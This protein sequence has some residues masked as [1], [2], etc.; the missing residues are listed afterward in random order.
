MQILVSSE[1][2]PNLKTGA[3]V[4]PVFAD[5]KLDGIAKA[6]DAL[7][8]GAIADVF[9][10]GEIAGKAG[11]TALLH[12]KDH[13]FKR[14]FLVGLGDRPK[15]ELKSLAKYAGTA[16]RYLGKRKVKSVAIALPAQARDKQLA[17]STIAE[18][19]I[20]ATL[21]TTLY[22][23]EPDK[24]VEVETVTILGSPNDAA[25]LRAG[26]RRGRI[27]GEAVNIARRMA[28]LPANDMT[29]THMA[30]RARELAKQ[31]GLR[32]D[33]LD[34]KRMKALGMGS[35]LGV[36]AGSSQPAKLIVMNYN[37]NPRSKEKLAIVGKGITFDSGGISIK[38]ATDMHEM[39][40][41]MSG[42]AAVIATMWALAQLKPRINVL[43]LAPASENLPGPDAVKPGDILRA[44]NG[45][46]IEVIN[47]DAEGRLV[48]ADAVAYANK[49]GATKII[50]AATLTGA[51]VVAL[52]HAAA[53]VMTN[54]E[55]FAAQ[56]L[57]VANGTPERYWQL[58]LYDDYSQE[59]KSEIADLKNAGGRWGG[60]ETGA[61]FIKAFV[62]ETPWIHLDVAGTAYLPNESPHMAKGPTGAPVRAFVAYIEALASGKFPKNGRVG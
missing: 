28:L 50:D 55:A 53:G 22:R 59:M 1:A 47:T 26:L 7:L 46:T 2:A 8:G 24:P 11:E 48:L 36:S 10:S 31:V 58:P 19:A 14:V 60:A 43:G 16:V 30:A 40:Y 12:T 3:L 37:G 13:A 38:P 42:A 9:A 44:M 15:F 20:E 32:I 35:L 25:A 56:F 61:A 29:P 34:E 45:K 18:G 33:V 6:V 21:D 5:A 49:L 54:D 4:V 17:A 51:C 52:G 39:K 57:G 41:D 27:I 62:G 23:S